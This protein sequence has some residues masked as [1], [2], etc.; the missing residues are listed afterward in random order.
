MEGHKKGILSVAYQDNN[1]IISGSMDKT[2]KIWDIEKGICEKT[3]IGHSDQVKFIEIV[4]NK[5]FVS[6]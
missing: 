3:I 5:T 4:N 6:A 2:I 1:T